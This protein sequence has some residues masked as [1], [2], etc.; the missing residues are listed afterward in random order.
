MKFCLSSINSMGRLCASCLHALFADVEQAQVDAAD[1]AV[2][3][4]LDRHVQPGEIS[5][6]FPFRSKTG[7]SWLMSC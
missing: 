3:P 1:L 5:K 7:I 2:R 4:R 6:P